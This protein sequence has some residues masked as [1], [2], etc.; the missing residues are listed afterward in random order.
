MKQNPQLKADYLNTKRTGFLKSIYIHTSKKE[1]NWFLNI[2]KSDL[3][4]NK[5]N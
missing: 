4:S 3:F 1:S 2:N 5:I